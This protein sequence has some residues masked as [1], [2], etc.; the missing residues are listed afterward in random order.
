MR[1]AFAYHPFREFSHTASLPLIAKVA[2]LHQPDAF[3]ASMAPGKRPTIYRAVNLFTQVS[4]HHPPLSLTPSYYAVEI[5][6]S[7]TYER[8]PF[9]GWRDL[10]VSSGTQNT[11]GRKSS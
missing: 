7:P 10:V 6:G 8:L 4:G 1:A 11:T 5:G 3:E 2:R 9:R